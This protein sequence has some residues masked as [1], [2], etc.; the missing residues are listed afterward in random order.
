MVLH[1]DGMKEDNY[2]VLK[3]VFYVPQFKTKI[4]SIK[5]LTKNG[6]D[7]TFSKNFCKVTTP[8]QGGTITIFNNKA[9][10]NHLQAR[11]IKYKLKQELISAMNSSRAAEDINDA[12]KKLG[13]ISEKQIRATY[14]AVGRTLKK[15]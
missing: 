3:K 7:V 13:H 2:I 15:H 5:K 8:R 1:I 11:I 6:Y 4:I 9:G 14:K 12:H 10:L